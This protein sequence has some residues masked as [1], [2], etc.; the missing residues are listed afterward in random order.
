MAAYGMPK[1]TEE[2]TAARGAAI[3]TALAG[4]ADVPLQVARRTVELLAAAREVT[5]V[6][7][8]NAASDGASAGY[9]LFAAT[10]SALANVAINVASLK[11]A[12]LAE[13]LGR[14]ADEIGE[15]ADELLQATTESFVGRQ[16]S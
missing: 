8:V 12:A 11:D 13:R 7:N 10:R 1:D 6:G 2:A 16:S 5:T 4:A 15:R 3:Q 14:E 9:V